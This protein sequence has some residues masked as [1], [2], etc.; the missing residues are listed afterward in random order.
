MTKYQQY[1]KLIRYSLQ[2]E[3]KDI[4]DVQGLDWE[5]LYRFA[6]EQSIA[7]VVF[8]GVAH[9]G[10][11]GVKPPFHLLME[12]LAMTEQIK[13]RNKILNERCVELT[14]QLEKDGFQCC[15]LKGQGN[16]SMYPN[17]YSRTPGD[18][19]VWCLPQLLQKEGRPKT[20]KKHVK[21]VLQYVR[22]RNPKGKFSF[23]HIDAGEF[24][25]VEVEMHYRPS[26]MNSLIHNRRLQRWF[27]SHTDCTDN[28]LVKGGMGS[29]EGEVGR[30]PV[31][32]REFNTV[33][34]LAHLYN[35]LIHEGI[36]LRQFVD[37]YYVLRGLAE[38][39]ENAERY[40]GHTDDTDTT[41]FY[42]TQKL[43][44]TNLTNHTNSYRNSLED[45]LRYLGL[46]KF[47]GAVM[48]V[49]REVFALE[50]R[51]MIAPVD[52]RRG[53]FLLEEIM[54]GGNFGQYDRR[55][56]KA[57]SQLGKN[58]KRL[59]RDIRLV[60]YFPSECLWEPVF[61]WYHFFWR[62]AHR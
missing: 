18:I 31:P 53:R 14:K 22:K 24:N 8:E 19:D 9:L 43:T 47:A 7:G 55:T 58:I 21:E 30:I 42:L 45:T 62:L 33:Y 49:M 27:I 4:P 2:S 40:K 48:Y 29:V 35:H 11:Q 41:D 17:P 16:A 60:R 12:W 61:R 23:H 38:S 25:G 36:G 51:Y 34:Q 20:M 57:Q 13:N 1:F 56:K 59:K 15:I 28:I 6:S 44:N 52:E 54:Q 32:T 46:W 37:Y 10:E 26:Y 39:A 50:E 5:R 3:T